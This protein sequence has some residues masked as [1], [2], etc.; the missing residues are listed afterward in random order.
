[1]AGFNILTVSQI[2]SYLKSYIDE[3]KKLS[4][5]YIKG[6]ITDFKTNFYSGHFYFSLKDESSEIRCVMFKSY[7][8]RIR[9]MPKDGMAVIVRCDLSV[10]Q[11]S[12]SCQLYVYDIQPDGLGAKHLAF[13]QLKEKLE[14]EGLFDPSLKKNLPRYPEKIGVITSATGA[15]VQDIINVLTR[16]WPVAK[17]VL[18]P[19]SVQGEDS[20]KQLLAAVKKQ[21]SEI[22]PDVIIIGRGGG[23][24]EDLSAFNDEEL[25]RAIFS[26]KTP[27][28]SAVGHET[29]FSICDFV[30]D[31]R[32]PTP[33]A[34]A[35]LSS[36]DI[37]SL[38]QTIDDNLE[39]MKDYIQRKCDDYADVLDRFTSV[40]FERFTD[41]IISPR[42]ENTEKLKK[43]LVLSYKNLLGN[44]QNSF[45]PELSKL[46]SNNPAKILKKSVCRIELDGKPVVLSNNLSVN[47]EIDIYF[48][49]GNIKATVTD[50]KEGGISI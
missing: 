29:D 18:T 22:K 1:M 20:P 26:C 48:S 49:D 11:K 30:A 7:S 2:N 12:C 21:D 37:N 6:E 36:P 4:G 3:N 31:M 46:D 39:W 40:K 41:K 24:S 43:E 50:K 10:Y 32:A 44:K 45:I 35:E 17:I 34:A 8:E 13:E 33:S 28:I 42:L 15:A 23:S 27:V 25:A 16:R 47:D 9:F 14:K 19:V 38:R 5:I